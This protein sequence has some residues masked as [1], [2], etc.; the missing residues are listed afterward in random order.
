MSKQYDNTNRGALFIEEEKTNERAPDM[1]GPINVAGQEYQLAAWKQ[2][3]KAGKKFLSVTIEPQKPSTKK[4]N[5]SLAAA[6]NDEDD[7]PF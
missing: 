7:L 1:K 2:T 5:Q 3:S 6:N 4:E